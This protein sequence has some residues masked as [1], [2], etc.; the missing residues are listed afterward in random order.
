[1]ATGLV[2]GESSQSYNETLTRHHQTSTKI[3]SSQWNRKRKRQKKLPEN[4]PSTISILPPPYILFCW[5]RSYPQNPLESHHLRF[6][7]MFPF[8][9]TI[10]HTKLLRSL[11]T[12]EVFVVFSWIPNLLPQSPKHPNNSKQPPTTKKQ[13]TQL[14]QTHYPL[15]PHPP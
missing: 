14:T 13:S 12:R 5:G 9:K 1:M 3:T 6:W 15:L 11:T 8:L 4:K 10:K 7:P 2:A